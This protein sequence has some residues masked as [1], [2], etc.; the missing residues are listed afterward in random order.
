MRRFWILLR[1]EFLA[2]SRDP[3][4][5]VGGLIPCAVMLV[6]FY[7]M[8]GG[9]MSL[10]VAVLDHDEGPS[11]QL[12]VD[13]MGKVLSPLSGEPY[14][15]V[16]EHTDDEAW[17]A[18]RA[19]RLMAVW[20]IPEDFSAR[21]AKGERPSVEM[22]FNNYNDDLAK[23]QRLYPAEILWRFYEELERPPP[24][25]ARAETYPL[26]E[27]VGW[28]PLI[29]VGIVLLGTM[30]GAMVNI[31]ALTH[32]E[33]Q[34]GITLELALS[35]RSLLVVFVAKALFSLSLSLATGLVLLTVVGLW[36]GFWP[37]LAHLGAVLLLMALVALFWTA[38]AMLV[39]FRSRE[40][41]PGMVSLMLTGIVVF[42][43]GGGL[44]LVRPNLAGMI[45][46]IRLFPNPWVVDP[47]RDLVLFG[48]WPVDF[49]AVVTVAGLLA[50]LVT[51]G[52]WWMAARGIR[53]S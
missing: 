21:L 29:A 34:Q 5:V 6:A 30:L 8:F 44:A 27:I 17:A 53:R 48:I 16:L 40:F 33:R 20:V 49:A 25:V 28:F 3:L 15:D 31:F 51:A 1:T 43:F 41:F 38:L 52:S 46:V 4:P 19:N 22:H 37:S 47:V 45:P 24:P 26:K 11:G 18:Y 32:R 39:A 50:G 10:S 12:L 35:P 36:L 42:F 2:Y 9:R 23:N 14:Y 7:L 13:V